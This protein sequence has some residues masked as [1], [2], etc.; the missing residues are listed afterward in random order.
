MK[1]NRESG[2]LYMRGWCTNMDGPCA[3]VFKHHVWMKR[4]WNGGLIHID[5]VTWIFPSKLHPHEFKEKEMLGLF[6]VFLKCF[7]VVWVATWWDKPILLVKW[8]TVK[9]H[10]SSDLSLEDGSRQHASWQIIQLLNWIPLFLACKIKWAKSSLIVDSKLGAMAW[11]LC[12]VPF[13]L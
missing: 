10:S 5:D 8:P 7:C 1:C 3:F 4:L 9:F 11:I 6:F 2:V 12:A 13:V